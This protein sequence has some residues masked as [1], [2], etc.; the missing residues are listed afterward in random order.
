MGAT[1][2]TTPRPHDAVYTEDEAAVGLLE[3]GRLNFKMAPSPHNR[4]GVGNLPKSDSEALAM[5]NAL[6]GEGAEPLTADQVYLHYCEAANTNFIGDRYMFMDATTLKNI[7]TDACAGF[8][9]MNSHRTGG[10]GKTAELPLGKTFCG[11]FEAMP[12]GD[13]GAC[14]AV[15]GLYMLRGQS[16][17]GASGP[18]TD[19][20]HSGIDGGTI[21]DCSVGLYGG[22][23]L[24]DVCGNDMWD[25]D[26]DEG[27]LCH[28]VPGSTYRMTAE[29]IQVQMDRGVPDGCCT[30]T[31][32]G[33]NC[34]EVSA[35]YDGAV[36]GAGFSKA[37]TLAAMGEIPDDAL[38]QLSRAY[39]FGAQTFNAFSTTPTRSP[40]HP[41]AERSRPA[42]ERGT[43]DDPMSV[44]ASPAKRPG[45][46][47]G[48][49]KISERLVAFAT[50]HGLKANATL[51]E[52][53]A[54]ADK[55]GETLSAILADE[56]AATTE[57]LTEDAIAVAETAT[58]AAKNAQDPINATLQ[59]R[60]DQLEKNLKDTENRAET[61][62][63]AAQLATDKAF[64]GRLVLDFRITP[65]QAEDYNKLAE[66]NPTAFAAVRPVLEKSEPIDALAGRRF[67][68]DGKIHNA[69]EAAEFAGGGS[70]DALFNQ[71]NEKTKQY[72]KDHP[73]VS[74]ADA[75]GAVC[76]ENRD[77]AERYR[78]LVSEG[79]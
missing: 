44:T 67:G 27:Y 75:F 71:L 78:A 65:A 19:A 14:R 2:A 48:K 61:D 56:S 57:E 20:I 38:T 18:S 51:S 29:Q 3:T 52:L 73:G 77:L 15:V 33:A 12:G 5:I 24:C 54:V 1:L 40:A 41:F 50:R 58:Q 32:C 72:L 68:S 28:H 49:L 55:D 46:S 7:S 62:R 30:Y 26:M 21:A 42:A 74:Q 60:I 17:N 6:R 11:R 23:S 16:P 34:S 10:Y 47:A 53:G 66:E 69:R 37:L 36:P 64:V 59:A 45:A 8:A 39:P 63:K 76:R 22:A 13:E 35:V 79:K 31:L 4:G 9:F 70:S 43:G 25:W